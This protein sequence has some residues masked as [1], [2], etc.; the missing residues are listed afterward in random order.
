MATRK[1]PPSGDTPPAF[2]CLNCDGTVEHTKQVRLF[3]SELCGEEAKFVRYFRRCKRDGRI[4]QS[5]VMEAIQIRFAHIMAGGY[6]ERERYISPAVRVAVFDRD[7]RL[8]Q[9]CGGPGTDI[10]HIAGD[11][12][13]MENVQL[14]C[15]SCHNEKTK[16]QMIEITPDDGRYPAFAKKS[17]LL[18]FRCESPLPLRLSDDEERWPKLYNGIMSDWR[19][20]LKNGLQRQ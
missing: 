11:S 2:V 3:C 8:C 1:R 4:N 18:R 6:R 13:E 15:R 5:D 14:L 19:K 7:R 12:S 10:D 20:V 17:K 16:E 9:K